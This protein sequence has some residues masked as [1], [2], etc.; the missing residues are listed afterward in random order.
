MWRM[1]SAAEAEI[2]HAFRDADDAQRLCVA[3]EHMDA[4]AGAGAVDPFIRVDLHA[5]GRARPL[6]GNFRLDAVRGE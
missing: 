1:S 6:A 4:G 3:A 2:G 5:V